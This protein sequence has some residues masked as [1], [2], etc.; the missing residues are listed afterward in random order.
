M[1]NLASAKGLALREVDLNALV[2]EALRF[3]SD[4]CRRRGVEV[5]ASLNPP[6][7]VGCFDSGRVMQVILNLLLNAIEAVP[8]NER[9]LRVSTQ[10]AA[11]GDQAVIAIEN[12]GN[13]IPEEVRRNLFRP[14]FTTKANGTGLGLYLSRQ[15]A[16]AHG[17]N[18]FVQNLENGVRFTVT[19]PLRT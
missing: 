8:A 1:L 3:V 2:F 14:F 6:S 17:G 11:G 18:I 10:I 15:N 5:E 13:P 9:R 4:E 12:S 19:L 16:Q 7:L